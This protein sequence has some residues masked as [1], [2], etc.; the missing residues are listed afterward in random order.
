MSE[1]ELRITTTIKEEPRLSEGHNKHMPDL[2][3]FATTLALLVIG[4]VIVFS[5]SYTTAIH[6]HG[7][8]FH[9]I[10]RQLLFAT[11]GVALMVFVMR[12]DY[13]MFRPLAVPGL[14]VALLLL[15]LVLVI[16]SEVG[17]GRRWISLGGFN[18]QPSE[19]AKVALINFMAAFIA[20]R[21]GGLRRFW[22]G[23]VAPMS[24]IGTVFVLILLEPDFGTAVA[25]GAT[26]AIML[27]AGGASLWHLSSVAFAALPAMG[28]LIWLEPYRMR[29][30]TSFWDPWADPLGAGWNVIQSLFAIGSGGLFGLGLGQG[31]QK[32]AYLP[33]QHTDFIFAVLGEELGFLGTAAVVVLFFVF[34]WRGLRVAL[35]APDLYGSML[36]V[37]V[38]SMIVVQALINIGVVTGSLPV[39]GITLPLIS[40]GGS[41]LVVTLGAIGVLLSVSRA[42]G[43]EPRSR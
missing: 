8:A 18:F 15:A 21:R 2:F 22:K 14:L 33:E 4:I 43:R 20:L 25:L 1:K 10:K 42:T 7:D 38:T 39:T 5:A 37:G 35:T 28:V 32:F 16:G 27:F 40:F 41:S 17:G 31:R 11:L 29:R 30:I 9:F 34:A 6:Q 23:F 24:I 36:A 19:V 13:R 3:I 12:L 26:A